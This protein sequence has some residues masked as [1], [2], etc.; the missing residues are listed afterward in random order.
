MGLFDG[1]SGRG[2]LASTAHV[3]K[4]LDAPVLLVV[5]AASMARSAAAIVHGYRTFDPDVRVAGVIFNRVGSDHHEQLLRDALGD[6]GVP[7][8]GALRRDERV[9]TPERHLGLIPADEREARAREALDTLSAAGRALRRSRR[10][11][12]PRALGAASAPARP[13]ARSPRAG[14]VRGARI[15]IARGPAFSFHYQENLELLEASGAELQPFDPMSDDALPEGA[16]ALI[17][18]G[19]FPEVYGGELAANESLR[20]EIGAFARSGRPVLAE[21]GGLL[22]LASELDG[23]AMC[24]ALPVRAT[25]TRRLTLGLSRGDGRQRDAVAR[26]RRGSARAR[27]PLLPGRAAERRRAGR[28]DAGRARHASAARA[29]SPAASRR[30]SCTCTGRPSRRSRPSRGRC[31]RA[32]S[33]RAAARRR[34]HRRGRL[35]RSRRGRARRGARRRGDRRL[36]APPR[37]AARDRR[38]AAAVA[39][40]DRRAA[41]RA[42]QPGR[43]R[44]TCVLASGDPM[45][46]GVGAT[47]ARR[48]GPEQ[49]AGAPASLGARVRVRAPGVA[50]GRCGARQRRRAA[51][52]GARASAAARP[53]A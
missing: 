3:A 49:A 37:A 25:M 10:G 1:A 30:A 48:L 47:L 35:G 45:L 8:L 40:A 7:V 51:A 18:A 5:D 41:G 52:R 16:G 2:E 50:G 27:V 32:R 46:H 4:L 9:A 17:L 28:L 53:P 43:C 14:R 34:R 31:P 26:R 23:Q 29:S 38:R 39:I 20:A 12:A 33:E 24:G 44:R 19:G 21:C 36:E 22:Y 15:A 13:G 42:R 11:D 6:L